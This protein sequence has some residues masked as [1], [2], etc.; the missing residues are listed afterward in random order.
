MRQLIRKILTEELSNIKVRRYNPQTDFD[1]IFENLSLVFYK[2]GLS[3]EEII[4]E[5]KPIDVDS[6][7]VIEKNGQL[8]G[9]YFLRRNQIPEKFNPEVFKKLKELNGVEGVA[10]GVFNEFKNEGIG[11]HLI[12]YPKTMGFDYIWGYQYESLGNISYWLKRRKLYGFDSEDNSYLTYQ[13][14]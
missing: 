9:F 4:N 12:N 6:S 2:T 5:I 1:I 14:Y 11:K 3:N 7:I 13:V 10:L 8:V